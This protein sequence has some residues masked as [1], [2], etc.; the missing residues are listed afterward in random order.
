M[1]GRKIFIKSTTKKGFTS[2]EIGL[3]NP[4]KA[5]SLPLVTIKK[6]PHSVVGFSSQIKGIV[7][8]LNA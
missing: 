2:R 3:Q 5:K 4:L 6:R 8:Q 7:D 1:D